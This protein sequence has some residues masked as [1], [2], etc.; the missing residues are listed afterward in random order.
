[1]SKKKSKATAKSKEEASKAL[2]DAIRH[3]K[4]RAM[5]EALGKTL[6]NVTQACKLIEQQGAGIDRQ[7]HYNWL[8][9]DKNYAAA[10]EAI[11][12]NGLDFVEGK[13]VELINGVGRKYT[14]AK[15]DEVFYTEPPSAVAVM[16]YLNNKGGK[17]G[18][19]N[20]VEI[21]HNTKG[22]VLDP[23]MPGDE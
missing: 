10:V 8:K 15:G 18:Y 13:L 3:P 16:F 5:V 23:E 12:D 11:A 20:R 2:I 21:Q 19:G 6:G 1:M 4:K 22:K 17:R 14:T 9:A 7:T